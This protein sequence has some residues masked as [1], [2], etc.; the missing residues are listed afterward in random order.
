MSSSLR[1]FGDVFIPALLL[2]LSVTSARSTDAPKG[3]P[4]Q[5][6]VLTGQAAFTD[7]AHESPGTRRH[8]TA[9]DLPGPA[10]EQSVD[11]GPTLVPRPANAWPTAPQG[12]QLE[13]YAI[14]LAN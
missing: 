14:G 6:A 8:L 13:L 10:P 11:N 2:S 5:H 1:I 9:A 7:A 4:K 12:L 3:P